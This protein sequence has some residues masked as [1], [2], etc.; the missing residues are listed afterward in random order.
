MTTEQGAPQR[1]ARAEGYSVEELDG[2]LLL[3]SPASGS[4][5][6][7]NQTAAL[8]WNLC[9]GSRTVEEIAALIA[10]AY[11]DAAAEIPGDVADVVAL[12]GRHGALARG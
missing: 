8:V 7:L 10:A 11:P 1:P 5:I 6:A 3:F 2:E 4:V 12:F 9:D